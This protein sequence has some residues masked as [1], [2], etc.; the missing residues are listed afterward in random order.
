MT[1]PCY[2]NVTDT[3]GNNTVDVI[4]T[5]HA[6][7]DLPGP[8][9]VA[10]SPDSDQLT[11]LQVQKK[12]LMVFDAILTIVQKASWLVYVALF[13]DQEASATTIFSNIES[14]YNCHKSNLAEL[15]D[16][17]NVAWTYYESSTNTWSLLRDSFYATL[18]ADAG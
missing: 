6:N 5:D 15:S 12:L 4:F 9:Y 17:Q 13:F 7:T 8:P 2:G 10:F 11:P 16:K 18:V 14:T 1:S 3:P